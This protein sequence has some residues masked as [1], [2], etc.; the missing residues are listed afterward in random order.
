V[1]SEAFWVSYG[2]KKA[3]Q[4]RRYGQLHWA[5]EKVEAF[6]DQGI[7][8]QILSIMIR[9]PPSFQREMNEVEIGS[10]ADSSEA[11]EWNLTEEKQRYDVQ[12]ERRWV[13]RPTMSSRSRQFLHSEKSPT[14]PK[15]FYINTTIN[16]IKEVL[17]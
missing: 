9:N 12:K 3:I 16:K 8:V 14:R 7:P 6:T 2:E 5:W 10:F 15:S 17:C 11:Q 4:V 1:A 13:L